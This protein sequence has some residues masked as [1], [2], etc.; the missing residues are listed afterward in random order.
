M[1]HRECAFCPETAKLTAEH[2][3]SDWM[4]DLFPGKK[5]F[6]NKNQKGEIVR[7]WES[8]KLDWKAKVVCSKC[9][10]TWMSNIE[11]YHAKPSLTD[12]IAGKLDIPI[13]Q[14][15]AHSIALFGF[16]TAVIFDRI[17]RNRDG[18]FERSVRHSFR[19]SL[20]IPWNVNM[21]MA[22]FLRGGNGHVHTGYHESTLATY[23][24]KTYVCT[25]AVGHFVF[26]VIAADLP[27]GFFQIAPTPGFEEVTIPFWPRIPDGFVWPLTDVLKTVVDFDAFSMRWQNVVMSN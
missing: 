11:N 17:V 24:L 26:Q 14:S 21:W 18:F 7:A 3:W 1:A 16:K 27:P 6:T 2:L 13:N 10:S 23:P 9:N 15:R 22:G 12:L 19:Q 4:N 25:Y 5:R 8:T 20:S